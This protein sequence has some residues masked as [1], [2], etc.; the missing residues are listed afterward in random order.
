MSRQSSSE[1]L[2][3]LMEIRDSQVENDIQKKYDLINSES[4]D[5]HCYLKLLISLP[6]FKS[7]TYDNFTWVIREL[8]NDLGMNPV[9]FKVI[10]AMSVADQMLTGSPGYGMGYSIA[11]MIQNPFVLDCM[12]TSNCRFGFEDFGGLYHLDTYQDKPCEHADIHCNHGWSTKYILAML[13]T[14]NSRV[15]GEF[16]LAELFSDVGLTDDNDGTSESLYTS[17]PAEED[18]V[19]IHQITGLSAVELEHTL[20][21]K[22]EIIERQ[23]EQLRAL[24]S[25]LKTPVGPSQTP[26]QVSYSKTLLELTKKVDEM[27][28]HMK[29]KPETAKELPKKYVPIIG[30]TDS[31]S[32]V[33][34]YEKPRKYMKD[35]TVY[36]VLKDKQI[37]Y[38]TE[39]SVQRPVVVKEVVR[40]FMKTEEMETIEQK[41]IANVRPINGLSNPFKSNRLN[42]LAHFHTALETVR[43]DDQKDDDFRILH[44]L[45]EYKSRTPSEELAH[46]IVRS[47]FDLNSQTVIANPHNLPYIEVG[48]QMSDNSLAKCFSL[49]GDEYKLLWFSEVKNL[50]PP[51]FAHNYN[52][53]AET[54]LSGT[55]KR[56][57]YQPS[58]TSSRGERRGRKAGSVLGF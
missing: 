14:D 22:N 8:I 46:Q 3:A 44:D 12:M 36:S 4:V 25:K 33:S 48:M 50:I 31:S 56:S 35:G 32:Q 27:S 40:G 57:R 49:L 37:G 51:S 5:G 2:R 7:C 9:G 29:A 17:D 1:T 13:F 24:T 19:M 54:R 43:R 42:K 30:P 38:Q 18:P 15:G 11:G 16:D 41:V 39:L 10:H 23:N 20:D 6:R 47:T 34:R 28:R 26:T 53:F 58:V 45:Y 55:S 21:E 52:Q